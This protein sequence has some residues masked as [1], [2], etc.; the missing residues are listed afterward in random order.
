MSGDTW[1]A[2]HYDDTFG[3]VSALGRGV[4]EQ[5]G[6]H[7]GERIVDL[8]CGT[9]ELAARI[10][11]TGA[12]VEGLD[13]DADMIEQARRSHP[14]LAFRVADGH[15]FEV[16]E[17]V[18]AVFSN[19]A[20]HWM[21]RPDRVIGRVHAALRPG[22]RFVAEF[23]GQGNVATI[24]G[25]VISAADTVGI[26]T[27]HLGDPWYFPSPAEHAGRLE[28]GG[29]RVRSIELIDRPTPLP[30]D[31]V[32]GWLRMFG[33]RILAGIPTSQRSEVIDLAVEGCRP[34]L[35]REGVWFADY[36]RLRFTAERV[37]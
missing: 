36:V 4:V 17:P 14:Q 16:D 5:L 37:G 20:L 15:R 22:G 7:P 27:D 8:G 3:F 30:A 10:A 21:R 18:D 6:A 34:T 28:S 13:A 25:A 26:A 35:L 23:G 19:A 32:A 29:F 2:K 31:G 12:L 33:G 11:S 24:R 1:D 9:G